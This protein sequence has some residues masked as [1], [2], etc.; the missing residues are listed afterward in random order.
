MASK[1]SRAPKMIRSQPA[2]DFLLIRGIGPALAG[3]LHDA[4]IHTY[5][6]LASL[7]TE[8]IASKIIGRSANQISHQDWIGQA[9]KMATPKRRLK[10]HHK[11]MITPVVHQY[12]ENFTIEC[13]LDEKNGLRRT[14]VVHVQSGDAETWPGW[15]AAQLIGFLARHAG[16]YKKSD[17]R[18]NQKKSAGRARN[19]QA[20]NRESASGRIIPSTPLPLPP[21]RSAAAQ[22]QNGIEQNIVPQHQAV[23]PLTGIL[24][25]QDLRVMTAGSDQPV[26]FLRQGQSY[27]IR[28]DLDLSDVH[29]KEDA[30]WTYQA[31]IHFNQVGGDLHP[32]S[33]TRGT[34]IHSDRVT[35]EIPGIDLTLGIYRLEAFVRLTADK[36]VPDLTA[37]LKGNLLHVY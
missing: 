10:S 7:T 12:Y 4:G 15:Q 16:V 31:T 21:A 11:E 2:D 8:E 17:S 37:F 32:V 35:L 23:S 19:L 13:L 3:K 9:R 18:L 5:R 26:N 30:M 20:G 25:L 14:R 28:L 6:Q 1:H 27:F 22:R 33:E 24:C 34:L 36:A 29:A